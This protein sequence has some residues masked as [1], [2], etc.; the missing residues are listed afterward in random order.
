MRSRRR[1]W[2]LAGGVVVAPL[3]A[4]SIAYACT[5]LATLSLNPS[6]AQPGQT[7]NGRGAGFVPHHGDAPGA[8]PVRIR[9]NSVSGRVLTSATPDANGRISFSFSTPDEAP[10]NYVIVATQN[11]TQGR[12]ASGTPARAAFRILPKSATPASAGQPGSPQ[13][14]GA[15]Q[16]APGGA[17]SPSAVAAPGTPG[18]PASQAAAAPGAPGATPPPGQ[19]AGPAAAP[20]PAGGPARAPSTRRSTMMA[21]GSSGSPLLAIGLVAAGLILT[22]GGGALVLAGRR[23]QRALA[24]LRR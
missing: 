2:Y 21:S 5:A 14:A 17:R 8:E 4:A 16:L 19:S 11:N 9:F 23:D 12:P 6:Q 18:Q 20:S 22:L 10:G 13:R 3:V 7:V 1:A 24:R 15:G